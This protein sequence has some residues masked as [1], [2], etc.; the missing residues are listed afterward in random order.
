MTHAL[1]AAGFVF[2]PEDRKYRDSHNE[3]R[4]TVFRLPYP[5]MMR[6]DGVLR[7]EIRI[8]LSAWPPRR[9]PVTCAVMSFSAEAFKESP[10]IPL[11]RLRVVN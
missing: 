5:T 9:E 7:Q 11:D 4:H 3:S 10:E 1:L 2:N 8:E 6:G